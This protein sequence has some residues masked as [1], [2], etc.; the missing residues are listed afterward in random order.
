MRRTS[1]WPRRSIRSHV[2]SVDASSTTM[3]SSGRWLEASTL[4]THRTAAAPPLYTGMTTLT[5]SDMPDIPDRPLDQLG[6]R[7]PVPHHVGGE[8]ALE[9]A[10][11]LAVHDPVDQLAVLGALEQ[12]R[13]LEVDVAE[14]A[15]A[16]AQDLARQQIAGLADDEQLAPGL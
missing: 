10:L 6:I 9:G 16:L 4:S 8:R 2:W 5:P 15:H 7:A 12:P 1:G 13:E 14:V 11:A 3:T